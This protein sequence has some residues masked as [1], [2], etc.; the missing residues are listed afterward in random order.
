MICEFPV[1]ITFFSTLTIL[2]IDRDRMASYTVSL[3]GQVPQQAAL[4]EAKKSTVKWHNTSAIEKYLGGSV[5]K[6]MLQW[7]ELD[8]DVVP[9]LHCRHPSSSQKRLLNAI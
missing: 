2:A 4:I 6:S 5:A 9:F 7:R 3:H 8:L 1:R